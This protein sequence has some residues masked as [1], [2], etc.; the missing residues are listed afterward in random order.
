MQ[1]YQQALSLDQDDVEANFNLAGL[2][3]QK[4]QKDLAMQHYKNSVKKDEANGNEEVKVLFGQQFAKAYFNIALIHD[5]DGDLK[6]AIIYYDK[7]YK[8]MIEIKAN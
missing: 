5:Q 3:L 2:H 1:I 7:S 8:K 6:N 4:Q